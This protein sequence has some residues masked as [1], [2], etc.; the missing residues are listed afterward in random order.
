[1]H[2]SARRHGLKRGSPACMDKRSQHNMPFCCF[3]MF[4]TTYASQ[5]VY[6]LVRNLARTQRN[7][8][9]MW[10]VRVFRPK[11]ADPPTVESGENRARCVTS[12][13]HEWWPWIGAGYGAAPVTETGRSFV[14]WFQHVFVSS[15]NGKPFFY[16]CVCVCVVVVAMS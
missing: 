10:C 16:V 8:R 13:G 2:E 4:P 12:H 7:R 11:Y 1:M 14:A 9:Q 3:L 6:M 5:R 15:V